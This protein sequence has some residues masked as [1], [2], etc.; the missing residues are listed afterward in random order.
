MDGDVPVG[1]THD[2][3]GAV[4][5]A[6]NFDLV[7]VGDLALHPE[8]YRAAVKIMGSP[9]W[10]FDVERQL[11]FGAAYIAA[12]AQGKLVVVQPFELS[13]HI[14]AYSDDKSRVTIV[15]GVVAG[16]DQA[17]PPTFSVVSATYVMAWQGD[18]RIAGFTTG[19]PPAFISGNP[20]PQSNQLPGALRDQ[21]GKYSYA[22]R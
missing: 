8:Q 13:Y 19:D 6:T 1:Y 3:K 21:T 5:A 4:A 16:A 10:N 7:L 17:K 12:A 18:W 22:P 9:E 20:A 14:D 2:Q 11:A 15:G